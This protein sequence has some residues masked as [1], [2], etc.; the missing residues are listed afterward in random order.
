MCFEQFELNHSA[1]WQTGFVRTITHQLYNNSVHLLYCEFN[2]DNFSDQ[3]F[4]VYG[5]DFPNE[6]KGAVAKRKAEFLA[7]RIA[8]KQGLSAL[9]LDSAQQ[10]VGIAKDRS[11]QWPKDV[12]GSISHT[13][14]F[15]VCCI[16]KMSDCSLIG[17]DSELILSAE[18]AHSVAAEIHNEA[19]LKLLIETGFDTA[20]VTSLIFSAKESLYKAL[21]PKVCC[22][23][24]FEQA[25]VSALDLQTGNLTL[26]LCSSFARYYGL[27]TDYKIQYRI[28]G[29]V[30]HTLL[31]Q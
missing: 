21:Y 28:K 13:S 7:G 6:I 3:C 4:T 2:P 22:F 11:P 15:A 26:S 8:A 30:V 1:H 16:A 29:S 10:Q 24:G 27:K 23:F 31:M 9:G 19:E 5:I 25:R 14:E 20:R 18:T 12:I 17:V